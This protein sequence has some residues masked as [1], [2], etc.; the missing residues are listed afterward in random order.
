MPKASQGT[1]ST[2]PPT[3]TNRD[4]EEMMDNASTV[5]GQITNA[6]ATTNP[7]QQKVKAEQQPNKTIFNPWKMVAAGWATNNNQGT[8][9]GSLTELPPTQ[10]QDKT[11]T[12]PCRDAPVLSRPTTSGTT[13]IYI[14][15]NTP[16]PYK[17]TSWNPG[18]NDKM[19]DWG[20]SPN[21]ANANSRWKSTRNLLAGLYH[22]K[23]ALQRFGKSNLHYH[24]DT[25]SGPL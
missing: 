24:W 5:T 12:G 16:G 23:L 17:I 25:N 19:D 1:Q 14:H 21:Y 3:Q 4:N 22:K 18:T 15:P 2:K 8:T 20:T 6:S 11:T 7:N 10:W 9:G 13:R